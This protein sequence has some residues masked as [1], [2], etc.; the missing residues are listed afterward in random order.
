MASNKQ[1][2]LGRFFD[3]AYNTA[4][5]TGV[6]Q[7]G[8]QP[9]FNDGTRTGFQ[10]GS[11]INIPTL[12][13][14][15]PCTFTPTVL[16]VMSVP[17]MYI[18]NGEMTY[19]AVLTKNL[20][21][22]HAKSVQGIDFGYTLST[23]D[24]PAGHDGQVQ[25]APG[26]TSRTTEQ[27]NFTFSELGNNI[28]FNWAKKWVW[29]MNHPDTNISGANIKNP[30][31]F[32]MSSYAMSML[33]IQYDRTG[34]PDQIIDAAYYTNMFP[35]GTGN[36][37]FERTIGN[38]KHPERSIPFTTIVQHNDYTKMLGMIVAE[39]LAL[40]KHNYNIAPTGRDGIDR[41]IANTGLW[42]EHLE[43]MDWARHEAVKVLD[44]T[45]GGATVTANTHELDP[46]KTRSTTDPR[47][48]T[49]YEHSATNW[50]T[51]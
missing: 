28:V 48:V 51:Q 41:T 7:S 24:T 32:T 14:S 30:G 34:R 46:T 36:I 11:G 10:L 16:V 1:E 8:V 13:V 21:E 33:A 5:L 50:N 15:T 18:V 22:S 20:I 37:G 19:M 29:D 42:T 26:K 25:A 40:H 4:Q 49:P 3:S 6:A 38:V 47:I 12:D 9:L 17:E 43:R 39:Q 27:P 45:P 2:H 44:T 23:V 35:T 31:A